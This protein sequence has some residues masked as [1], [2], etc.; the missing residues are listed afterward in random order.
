[1]RRASV[2]TA[3]GE[4]VSLSVC[5]FCSLLVS[6]VF[7]VL[8]VADSAA[9]YNSKFVHADTHDDDLE[10]TWTYTRWMKMCVCC[11]RCAFDRSN[12]TIALAWKIAPHGGVCSQALAQQRHPVRINELERMDTTLSSIYIYRHIGPV[13]PNE[14]ETVRVSVSVSVR[15]RVAVAVFSLFYTICIN[16]DD[17]DFSLSSS[18]RGLY[19]QT[20]DILGMEIFVNNAHTFVAYLFVSMCSTSISVFRY[21]F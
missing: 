13:Y 4:C 11:F 8:A 5:A 15:T 17:D 9:T 16:S 3:L 19:I 10:N 21:L 7:V 1:M 18:V 2:C 14:R 20:T 6:V 12:R